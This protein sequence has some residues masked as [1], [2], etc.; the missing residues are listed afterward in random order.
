MSAQLKLTGWRGK[1]PTKSH[2]LRELLSDLRWHTQQEMQAVAGMRFGARLFELHREE[3]PLH[4]EREADPFDDSRIL[5]RIAQPKDCA[6]C[7][8]PLRR[9]LRAEVRLLQ[10]HVKRLEE[11]IQE[12]QGGHE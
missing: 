10:E 8:A 1:A 4:Y 3:S 12:I 2:A 6:I 11:R 9:G 7:T 5:Y